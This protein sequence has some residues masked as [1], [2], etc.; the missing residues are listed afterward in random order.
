MSL[1]RELA[2]YLTTPFPN[3][4]DDIEWSRREQSRLADASP[5]AS[6]PDSVTW[7]DQSIATKESGEP[8]RVRIYRPHAVVGPASALLFFHGGAF[9]FGGLE[10]EHSR[11]VRYC[12]DAQCVVVSVEYSLAPEYPFPTAFNEAVSSLQ[13]LWDNAASLEVDPSRIG[14][15]GV[16]AGGAIASGLVLHARDTGGPTVRAQLLVYPVTDSSTN[17]PSMKEFFHAE[18]F[19]GERA[20]KMW[21]LYVTST[22]QDVP[23]YASVARA[24]ELR[25]MPPT[26]L[27]TADLDPLR[28]EGLAYALALINAGN[29]V[30]LH[31]F[32]RTYHGFDAVAPDARLSRR[33]LTE[34]CLFLSEELGDAIA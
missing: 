18:P 17:T 24:N 33:A 29:T 1:D 11:C 22:S 14:V 5:K 8:L 25:D 2:T 16:S 19:D 26:Y 31:H 27:V 10:S 12:V 13:W 30:E 23:P 9:V 34:Q 3:N 28:D 21:N 4:F 15:A 7:A 6:A 32:P 20:T